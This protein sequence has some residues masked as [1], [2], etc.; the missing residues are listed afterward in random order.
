M[1]PQQ[2]IDR[3]GQATAGA[4][5]AVSQEMLG[6]SPVLVAR[7]AEFKLKWMATKLHTFVVAAPF[8]PGTAT[9]DRLDAFMQAAMQF[10]KANKGGLPVGLQTGV[11]AVTVA[12]TEGADDTTHG[13]A[14]SPHG[15]KFGVMSFPC[16]ADATTGRVTRPDRM[17]I[18]GVYSG[19]LKSVVD[20]LVAPAT[21]A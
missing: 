13:W 9:P 16:V 18:G 8:P 11:A 3:I 12:V 20:T 6:G 21:R 14:A 2:V 4:G 5:Y 10:A 1:T 7:T 15:R 17:V 19:H